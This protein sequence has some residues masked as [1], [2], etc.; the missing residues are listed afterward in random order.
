MIKQAI[1]SKLVKIYFVVCE[2]YENELQYYCQR[3]T[4]N[5]TPEFT[6]QEIMTIYLFSVH[7]EKRFKIKEMYDFILN[8]YADWFPKLPSYVAFNTRLNNL[9]E[10]FRALSDSLLKEFTPNGVNKQ[11]SLLDSMPI[12]TCSGKRQG[13]VATEI[14]D[15]GYCSTKHMYYYGVKLHALGFEVNNQI[16]HPESIIITKASENDLTVFK[17]NWSTIKNRTFYG[18]KIYTDKTFFDDLL[19]E[20]NSQMLTPVKGVK[21]KNIVLIQFDKAYN[22]LFSTAVSTVR[23]PIESLFNWLIEKT[24]IQKASKVRSTKGL[25][26]HLFGKIAA[27]FLKPVFNS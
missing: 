11:N 8:Y 10:A 2:K 19:K 4:N 23:Q 9:C 22:D 21:A 17:E 24:D 1:T 14:T 27:A 6:D 26:V 25:L 7:L 16:P 5:N 15:K 18:D 20:N 3:F 12:I 13:K